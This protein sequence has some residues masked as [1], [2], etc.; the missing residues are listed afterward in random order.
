MSHTVR[1]LFDG[2]ILQET[3]FQE[4][5][6]N[7][8]AKYFSSTVDRYRRLDTIGEITI[9]QISGDTVEYETTIPAN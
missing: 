6:E 5:Q 4:D 1:V 2:Q 7:I 9:Q 8:A 3:T